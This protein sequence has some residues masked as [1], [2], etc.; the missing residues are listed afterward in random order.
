MV[1][2]EGRVPSLLAGRF[3]LG[4]K[5]GAGGF[6]EVYDATDDHS[7][8]RVAL[9]ILQRLDGKSLLRF[10]REFRSLADI[11]HDNLVRLDEL[12]SADDLWFFTMELVHGVSFI[13]YVQPGAERAATPTVETRSLRGATTSP[14]LDERA[15][16]SP[17]S[18][19][20]PR[21]AVQRSEARLRTLVPQLASGIAALHRAGKIHRDL[22]PSNVLV[23]A[24]NRVVILDLGM[25]AEVDDA[26]FCL[27]IEQRVGTPAYMAPEQASG[28]PVSSASDWYAVGV[29]LYEALTAELPFTGSAHHMMLARQ[30][31]DG[32]D[33]RDRDPGVPSDLAE[34]CRDLLRVDPAQRPSG[35]Q[36]LAVFEASPT[37]LARRTTSGARVPAVSPTELPL[38]G[39]ERHLGVL[40]RALAS[41]TSGQTSVVFVSGASGI[42]KSSLMRRFVDRVR[43]AHEAIVL[44]G[45]CFER[46]S[47]PYNALDAVVD[48]LSAE[49]SK[50]EPLVVAKLTPRHITELCSVFPVL[51]RVTS[52]SD[53]AHLVSRLADPNEVRQRAFAALKELLVKM[54]ERRP[55]VVYIDD[56]QW[57]DADSGLALTQLL[58]P[59]EPPALLFIV[60]HRSDAREM[61]SLPKFLQAYTARATWLQVESLEVEPLDGQTARSL[62]ALLAPDATGP[63]LDAILGEANGHPY[64]VAELARVSAEEREMGSLAELIR[65]RVDALGEGARSLLEAVAIAGRP[66]SRATAMAV[67]NAEDGSVAALSTARLLRTGARGTDA[68]ETYHDRIRETVC[69]AITPERARALH[70]A[71]GS[72]LERDPKTPALVL[73]Q[74]FVEGDVPDKALQFSRAAA[75]EAARALA[76]DRAADLFQIAVA[77]APM[78]AN[79]EGGDP[80]T[81]TGAA[82]I[83]SELNRS[84]GDA[85]ANAG[86]GVEA[87]DAY[88]RAA[89][90][91]DANAVDLE[92]RA[93]TALLVAGHVTRGLEVGRAVLARLGVGLPKSA[94]VAYWIALVRFGWFIVRG[95]RFK[96]RKASEIDERTLLELDTMFA[97]GLGLSL[98]DAMRSLY[99]TTAFVLSA[100]R[101]GETKRVGFAMMG[102]VMWF[103]ALTGPTSRSPGRWIGAMR[104][105]ADRNG[106]PR[107][108][109]S[110][111]LA[112]AF[113]NFSLGR[114]PEARDGCAEAERDLVEESEGAS[115]EISNARV[116]HCWALYHAGDVRE[117]SV[118]APALVELGKRRNDLSLWCRASS[119]S[120]TVAWLVRDDVAGAQRAADEA[121]ERW[122]TGQ[123]FGTIHHWYLIS[124][125]F[126]DLYVGSPAR[127]HRHVTDRWSALR[128][129][130]LLRLRFVRQVILQIRAVS[131]LAL[132]EVTPEHTRREELLDESW[133]YANEMPKLGLGGGTPQR[134]LFHAGA[135]FLRG[136]KDASIQSL[137]AAIAGFEESSMRL[138]R[139]V[140]CARLGALLPGDE[141]AA[142][143]S[144][145]ATFMRE[146]SIVRPDRFA[147]MLAPGFD[148]K[149]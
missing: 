48:A 61:G 147:A 141:G 71:I 89:A 68:L 63:Q 26:G 97:L 44:E 2:T 96:E 113:R 32:P 110:A 120:S 105:M 9:K 21:P 109:G 62:A 103:S 81:T 39:R 41:A 80:R 18:G 51:R 49:L 136:Q 134:D 128:A 111:A 104:A 65:A 140:A 116:Y 145:A 24:D 94:R 12:F 101:V 31:S 22:K 72:V 123:P 121:L 149:R 85:L 33:P 6:G 54:A 112:E 43:D 107:L 40:R 5:I 19:L 133:R 15:L 106:S 11:T 3:R 25:V 122:P 87:A 27:S 148:V 7:G 16:S 78:V 29:M 86:R 77:R 83:R 108:R 75:E 79:R 118:R 93:A 66:L 64:F 60:S 67:S 135:A 124:A 102:A 146:Q 20:R 10:K 100:L 14:S 137:R 47:V 142:L 95:V 92:R 125:R 45:R 117:L 90:D 126:I 8:S 98:T 59:P 82:R 132:A 70:V 69:A 84:L 30:L 38:V 58:D 23:T 119:A 143:S 28:Q 76:F 74:H 56:L 130:G 139:A 129:A 138:H 52:F 13:D 35:E 73:A 4:R 17:V 144:E 91:D 99:F 36:V 50:L 57:G 1:R 55:L 42:G 53:D 88:L 115:W 131:A 34:L 46:E 37:P 127:L 114:W